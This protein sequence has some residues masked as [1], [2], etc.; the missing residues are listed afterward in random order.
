MAR[1]YVE[2]HGCSASYADSEIISGILA[3]GGH[4]LAA[5]GSESDAGV[6]VTCSVKDATADKMI[7][8]IKSM[9][10]KPLVVAGCM[11]KAERA[12]VEKFSG[13][14]SLMGPDSLGST[15]EMVRSALSGKKSVD[16]DGDGSGKLGLPRVRLNEAVSIIQI[17]SGCMSECS[18]CQTKLAKGGLES[19]RIGDIV[20][21][22]ASDVSG[23]CRE[24]WL[25]ST[26]N[27]C[28]GL[29][30]GSDLPSL[31]ESVAE[32]PGDFM[33]R[34]GMM[35]PMYMPRIRDRLVRSYVSGRVYK[36][37]H[38]PVQSGSDRVLAGMRRGHTAETFRGAVRAFRAMH[39]EI[40]ISTDVIIGF[41]T[42]TDADFEETLSLIQETRPDMVNLSRY[43]ARPG[44]EA[45]EM[46]QLDVE[47][48]R[49]RSRIIHD[50]A[51]RISTESN[52]AWVGWRGQVLF[53]ERTA[54]GVRGR[55]F[56]YRPVHV[57]DPV[58]VGQRR[59]VLVTGAT[60]HGLSGELA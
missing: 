18:F 56:A 35:N 60:A 2:A 28:Y 47:V 32:V 15:L 54:Q 46:D 16:L 58:E 59:T 27:G 9:G 43:G 3:N 6:L 44:T 42:E 10:E 20:R 11:P 14:A 17:A 23:G 34:V 29:D 4:T 55:N 37:L 12:T 33:V 52:K 24:V 21:Q 39:P 31:V 7:H 5:S 1:I 19:Y 25:S 53:A 22:V 49:R 40:T 36:F 41:P 57:D 26:D 51:T 38:V 30:I 13:G 48:V 45:A 8:R 50:T